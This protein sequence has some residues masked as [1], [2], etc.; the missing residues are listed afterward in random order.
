M[1]Q[2]VTVA[3]PVQVAVYRNQTSGDAAEEP[4]V[5]AKSLVA[6]MIVKLNVPLPTGIACAQSSLDGAG[7]AVQPST[8]VPVVLLK[9]AR[10]ILYELPTTTGTVIRDDSPQESSVQ[11]I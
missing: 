2:V 6:P 7:G 4:Q 8:P 1:S 11:V 3:C 5:A 9:P 10:R